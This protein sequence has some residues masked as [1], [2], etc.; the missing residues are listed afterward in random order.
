[1]IAV[2]TDVLIYVHR[3]ETDLHDT[4]VTRNSPTNRSTNLLVLLAAGCSSSRGRGTGGFET[5]PYTSS[6]LADHK[7]FCASS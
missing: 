7:N 1:M 3:A 5:R 2:D 6:R 4:A